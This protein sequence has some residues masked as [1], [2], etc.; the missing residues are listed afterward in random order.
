[1]LQAD[2]WFDIRVW[3][4]GTPHY[5]IAWTKQPEYGYDICQKGSGYFY[6]SIAVIRGQDG[7]WS[8]DLSPEA[9]P[10]RFSSSMDGNWCR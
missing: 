7:Q 1:M 6:W 5:G 9:P 8:A 2:E 4:E 3:Q 10:R